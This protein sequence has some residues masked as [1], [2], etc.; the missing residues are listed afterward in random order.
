MVG[1]RS[2]SDASGGNQFYYNTATRRVSD[3]EPPTNPLNS[4]CMIRPDSDNDN[5]PAFDNCPALK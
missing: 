1:A 2:D 5:V 4:V 3:G